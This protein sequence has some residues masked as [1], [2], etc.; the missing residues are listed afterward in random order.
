MK[1]SDIKQSKKI[2]PLYCLERKNNLKQ[3]IVFSIVAAVL[4]LIT[5]LMFLLVDDM[6]KMLQEMFKDNQELYDQL[7]SAMSAATLPGY[8]VANAGSIWGLIGV[9]YAAY[10]GNKLINGNLK[11]NSFEMLYTLEY[12]R[13]KILMSKL[14]RLVI[15]V[16][17][18]NIAVAIFGFIGVAIVGFDQVNYANYLL[19]V[20]TQIICCLQV[21]II[22]F[23]LTCLLTRKFGT[24]LSIVVAC[25]FNFV[26]EM[27]ITGASYKFLEYLSPC[28]SSYAPIL[29]NGLIGFNFISLA[30]WTFVAAVAIFVGVK[31]FNKSDII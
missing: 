27:A 28:F 14:L 19:Y 3:L 22:S 16:V 4:T 31:K 30:I 29:S 13:T 6:L 26:S 11:D 24:I 15:N 23:G 1:L 10:L 18:F 8:F 21:G 20:L 2:N 17:V 9:V 25:V 5:T 7:G 12:S